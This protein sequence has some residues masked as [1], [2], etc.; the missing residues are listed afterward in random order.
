MKAMRMKAFC[1]YNILTI[2]IHSHGARKRQSEAFF[3]K[4]NIEQ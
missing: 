3:N 4:K 1:L 2:K